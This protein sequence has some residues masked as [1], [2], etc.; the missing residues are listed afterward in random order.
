MGRFLS[1]NDYQTILHLN[2]ELINDVL[3]TPVVLYKLNTQTTETNS[4]GEAK[5]KNWYVPVQ[6]PCKIE[7]MDQ[8]PIQELQTVD[9][10]QDCKFHFLR[11]E[12]DERSI[13]PERGD[14]VLFNQQYYEVNNTIETQMWG[15]RVEF[16][17]SVICEAQLT[18]KTNLQLELPNV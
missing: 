4:Y 8:R 14:I 10:A 15:G 7:R 16:K 9:V 18:R 13:Y 12:L 5:S 1:P 6:V 11:S 3:D 2:K 17:H